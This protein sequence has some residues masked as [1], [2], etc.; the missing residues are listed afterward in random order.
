MSWVGWGRV[1]WVG[2][3]EVGCDRLRWDERKWRDG[4]RWDGVGFVWV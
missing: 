4:M 3:G 1:E 2:W